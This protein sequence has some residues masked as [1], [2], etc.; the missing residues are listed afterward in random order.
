[1]SGI[2]DDGGG[3]QWDLF[4][5]VGFVTQVCGT[6]IPA[7]SILSR[8]VSHAS[9]PLAHP[10]LRSSRCA[11]PSCPR[12]PMRGREVYASDPSPFILCG[13]SLIQGL[14]IRVL[15]IKVHASEFYLPRFTHLIPCH[16]PKSTSQTS[17][18]FLSISHAR[19]SHLLRRS[20]LP[21]LQYF[22]QGRVPPIK[23]HASDPPA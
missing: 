7:L 17:S 23:V 1:M 13:C 11:H 16:G 22:M 14:R 10:I 15:I 5:D 19:E 3:L 8:R 18:F 21:C 6:S 9:A 2:E 20:H 4:Q 12:N